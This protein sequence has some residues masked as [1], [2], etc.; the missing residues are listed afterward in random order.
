MWQPALI[1]GRLIA[2]ALARGTVWWLRSVLFVR[3]H[4]TGSGSLS[5]LAVRVASRRGEP[6]RDIAA[7]LLWTIAGGCSGGHC[8]GARN[9]RSQPVERSGD[10]PVPVSVVEVLN[11]SRAGCA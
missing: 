8:H 5:R 10:G 6:W 11:R 9:E 4:T 7:A 2:D 1:E 3:L